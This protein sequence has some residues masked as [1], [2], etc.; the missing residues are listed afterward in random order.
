M[1]LLHTPFVKVERDEQQFR[2]C[3]YHVAGHGGFRRQ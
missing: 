2:W 1:R 3:M